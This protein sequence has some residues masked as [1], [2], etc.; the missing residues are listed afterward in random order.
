[1]VIKHYVKLRSNLSTL[2]NLLHD[3]GGV[4]HSS[5]PN[6]FCTNGCFKLSLKLSWYK[7]AGV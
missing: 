7:A 4:I 5:S 3:L 1:M 2:G 6:N